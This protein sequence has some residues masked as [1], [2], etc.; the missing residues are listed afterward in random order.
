MEDA[1]GAVGDRLVAE[2]AARTDHA[3]R[4]PL[5][6]HRAH[7]DR[8]GVRAQQDVGV[9]LDEE[10]VL[11][12]ACGVLGR[13]VERRED[14]PVVLDFGSVGHG[15][16]QAREDLDDF[17][18]DECDRVA[19]AEALGRAGARQVV[20]GGRPVRRGVLQ[21]FAQGVYPL[22]GLLLEAVE[23][24]AQF[25]FELGSHR[26]ELLHQC[27]Q[28][29]LFAEHPDPEILDFGGRLGFELFDSSEEFIDFVD[30]ILPVF[31]F[32]LLLEE[33]CIVCKVIKKLRYVA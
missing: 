33:R 31:L 2:D 23:L 26:L 7:L 24:L 10:R 22:R 9:L 30:H 17:V 6:L 28:L 32:F 16:A 5:A 11:H 25:A 21:L 19:R 13:E 1:V 14:V 3:D 18:P 4:R 12:V 8:R 27:V 29:A 20:R 15:V